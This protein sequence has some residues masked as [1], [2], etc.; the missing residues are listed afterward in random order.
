MAIAL[1][2]DEPAELDLIIER[3]TTP[4]LQFEIF[5]DEA[6]TIAIDVDDFT[7]EAYIKGDFNT[8]NAGA[9]MSWADGDIT[10]KPDAQ[11]NVIQIPISLSESNDSDQLLNN[12]VFLLYMTDSSG[13]RERIAKG[14][15]QARS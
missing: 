10:K 8:T 12:G 6:Q 5:E 2:I 7:F 4:K 14:E 1:H 11:G 15:I 3:D 9:A 13:H